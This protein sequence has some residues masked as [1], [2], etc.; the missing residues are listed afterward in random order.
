[1]QVALIA[2]LCCL[3][4]SALAMP[5]PEKLDVSKA[6]AWTERP[7]SGPPPEQR[8]LL[9]GGYNKDKNGRDVWAMA[10]VP[11]Y[12]S[13][14]KRHEFDAV[15]KYGQHLGGPY[16]NSPPSYGFGGNYRFRF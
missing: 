7:P 3:L 12:T 8:F 1:M 9:D 4:G 16:G 11:V 6:S 14:N 10:Q 13:D 5:Q 15:G 2:L